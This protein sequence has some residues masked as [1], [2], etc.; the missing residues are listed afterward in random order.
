MNRPARPLGA[1]KHGPL[2]RPLV[3]GAFA[4]VLVG[5]SIGAWA[6]LRLQLALGP[7]DAGW[8]QAHGQEQVFGFL[9]PFVMGFASYLFPRVAAGRPL[10]RRRS[11]WGGGVALLAGSALALAQ[12]AAPEP[13]RGVLLR[14]AGS[15]VPAGALTAA[16]ALDGPFADLRRSRSQATDRHYEILLELSLGCLAL[17]GL[18]DGAALWA[19]SAR[20]DPALSSGL[21]SAAERLGIEGFAVG[22]ALGL[23]SRMFPGFLGVDPRRS[24]PPPWAILAWALAAL[25][26]AAGSAAAVPRLESMGDGLFAVP[27]V[28]LALELGFGNTR[29]GPAIDRTRDPIFPWGARLAY[30][31]LI[32]A[33]LVRA[34]ADLASEWG[35]PAHAFWWDAARH[36]LVLGFL[37]TLIATMAGRLA[38][39]FAGRRLRAPFLRTF[40]CFA[41]PAAALLRAAEAVAGQWGPPGLLGASAA[42]GPLAFLALLALAVSVTATLLGGDPRRG[43]PLGALR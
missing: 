19:A 13:A 6:L 18:A 8:L 41:F 42:S 40:A 3:L 31:F 1:P 39:G 4:S 37:M 24:R 14:L 17:A 35:L 11:L 20:L 26:G 21:A 22:T 34:A 12:V 30:L 27:A 15:L 7:V 25:L 36:E 9:L 10:R 16:F 5:G 38:P 23:S 29:G 2:L 32:T 33:A 28:F 43:A